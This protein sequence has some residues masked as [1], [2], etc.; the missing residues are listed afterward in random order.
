MKNTTMYLLG[1]DADVLYHRLFKNLDDAITCLEKD[2]KDD[3]YFIYNP[4]SII[5]REAIK[6][7]VGKNYECLFPYD[8]EIAETGFYIEEITVE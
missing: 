5:D 6:E 7:R 2:F 1:N 3:D 4:D 8:E